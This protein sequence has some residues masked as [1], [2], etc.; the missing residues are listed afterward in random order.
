MPPLHRRVVAD[1]H[2]LAARDAAD[3]GDHARA[4]DVIVVEAVGGELA[5][6]EEGA[7]GIEQA[8]DAIAGKQLAAGGVALAGFGVAAE[9]RRRDVGAQAVG[10][11]A[12]VR[13]VTGEGLAVASDGGGERG[14]GHAGAPAEGA[15]RI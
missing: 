7:A 12:V 3:A 5:D 9:A 10:E 11:R 2:D 15:R 13:G 6:F 14:A 1:D 4:G 8:F